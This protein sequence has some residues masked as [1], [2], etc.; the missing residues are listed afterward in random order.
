MFG[1]KINPAYGYE[2]T[3]NGICSKRHL[4][5]YERMFFLAA[6]LII[7]LKWVKSNISMPAIQRMSIK[8]RLPVINPGETQD[9]A[10]SV[11]IFI[12]VMVITYERQSYTINTQF[13]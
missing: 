5:K 13:R 7:S 3:E 12:A 11:R 1:E 9:L 6:V 2:D 10:M 8:H 4:F